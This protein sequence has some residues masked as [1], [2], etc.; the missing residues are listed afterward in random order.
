[1]TGTQE[2]AESR[3][4]TTRR[5]DEQRI[6]E[7]EAKI[8]EIRAREESKKR[9]DDP[10]LK[11]VPRLQRRLRKFAQLAAENERLDIAN[12]VT[13]W[14]SSLDRMVRD[15]RLRPANLD[16]ELDDDGGDEI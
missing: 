10:L 11:D 8:A 2:T 16:P 13:A 1:M 4:D 3:R 5:S 12:S 9:K 14:V 6:K 15:E 7:L